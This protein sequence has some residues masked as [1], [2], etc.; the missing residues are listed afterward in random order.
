[1]VKHVIKQI[2]SKD[3]KHSFFRAT[4]YIHLIQSKGSLSGIQA[5]PYPPE[6]NRKN[7]RG[8][9]CIW[10]ERDYMFTFTNISNSKV[11][12]IIRSNANFY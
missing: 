3:N 5:P 1:M 6:F 12:V 11:S 10:M 4:V 8:V 2:H 7:L 9:S